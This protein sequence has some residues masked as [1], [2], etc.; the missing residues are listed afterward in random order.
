MMSNPGKSIPD[1]SDSTSKTI[2]ARLSS[3]APTPALPV[4]LLR[5]HPN[6]GVFLD[7]AAAG[8]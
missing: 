2:I 1:Q 4:S 7:R 3:T 5:D 6:I 8:R